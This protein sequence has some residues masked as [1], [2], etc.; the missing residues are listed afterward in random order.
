MN[1]K[2]RWHRHPVAVPALTRTYHR[3]VK[4]DD[5]TPENKKGVHVDVEELV[6][7]HDVYREKDGN[8]IGKVLWHRGARVGVA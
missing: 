4:A 8:K 3:I 7:V 5:W 6:H 2:D 1:F